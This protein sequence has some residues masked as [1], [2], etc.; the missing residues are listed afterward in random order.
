[1]KRH[2][3]PL[4]FVLVALSSRALAMQKTPKVPS[5]VVLL[6]ILLCSLVHVVLV[7]DL[8]F[9]KWSHRTALGQH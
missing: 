4:Q 2:L 9:L 5:Y 1:M 6:A 8:Q 3:T 7:V